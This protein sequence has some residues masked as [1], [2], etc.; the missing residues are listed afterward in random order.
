MGDFFEFLLFA[1]PMATV[2]GTPIY[3]VRR[4]IN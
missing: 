2:I 1:V 4:K 3:L